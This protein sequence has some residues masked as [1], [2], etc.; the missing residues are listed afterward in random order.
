MVIPLFN[1]QGN[2]SRL[3]ERLDEVSRALDRVDVEYVLVDD[4]SRDDTFAQATEIARGRKGVTVLRLARNYG[5][6]AAIAAGLSNSHGDCALFIAGDLQ[7]P[8]QI[9]PGMLA[10]WRSG[11]KVVWAARTMVQDQPFK[12]KFF[13][14]CYWNLFNFTV[15]YPVP[16]GGVDFALMDRLVVEAIKKQAHLR[17]PIFA[18]I[19]DTGFPHAVVSYTK[20]ARASGKSGWTLSKKFGLVFQTLSCSVKPL[21]KIAFVASLFSLASLVSFS[22]WLS[23]DDRA[24]LWTSIFSLLLVF[25]SGAVFLLMLTEHIHLRLKGM[26]GSPRFVIQTAVTSEGEVGKP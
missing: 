6:H 15:D 12:D 26:E 9:I 22:L 16:S 1:E 20:N 14:Q 7:D 24:L 10:K 5:S 25:L 8:P 17:V 2:I 13:S 23:F 11:S 3:F 19:T 4:G 21:R 18:Q